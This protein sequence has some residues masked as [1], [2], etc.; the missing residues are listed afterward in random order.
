MGGGGVLER[1]KR[2]LKL[3]CLI[4]VAYILQVM[5]EGGTLLWYVPPT[6]L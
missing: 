6:G 5:G 3:L 2:D 4:E 1:C